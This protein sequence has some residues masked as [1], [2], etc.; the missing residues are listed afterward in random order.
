MG[1]LDELNN[2]RNEIISKQEQKR[3][4]WLHMY[5]LFISLFVLGLEISYY[6]FLL[7]FVIIIPYQEVIN[8]MEWNVSRISAYIRT[9]YEKDN[10][11]LNWETM[12]T[13]YRPYLDYLEKR[14]KGVSGFVRN[15][16]SIHLGFLA[17][18]FFV[19]CLLKENLMANDGAFVLSIA[20][21]FLILFSV[22][23][24]FITVRVNQ[25]SKIDHK[26]YLEPLMDGYKEEVITCN[27]TPAE[28]Q[29]S[30]TEQDTK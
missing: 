28:E 14:V 10:P 19:G 22:G 23:M 15:A 3:N 4:V 5:I 30:S 16:G 6:L 26:Q 2:L 9:F 1:S 18:A 20:D 13:H 24:F 27:S 29:T 17:T 8:N 7:T 21:I 11:D 12:N 25:E